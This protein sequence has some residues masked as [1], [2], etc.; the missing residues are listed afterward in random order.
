MSKEGIAAV[1]LQRDLDLVN[2]ETKMRAMVRELIEPMLTKSVRDRELIL[3]LEKVDEL[4]EERLD[5]L[6]TCVFEKKPGE[7]RTKFDEYDDKFVSYQIELRKQ[8]E[9]M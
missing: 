9:D 8:R 3:A 5:L 6:E 2:F 4:S 7:K 1:Y